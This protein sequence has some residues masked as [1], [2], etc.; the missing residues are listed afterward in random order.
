MF[1]GLSVCVRVCHMCPMCYCVRAR[2][3]LLFAQRKAASGGEVCVCVRVCSRVCVCVCVCLRVY[4][5]ASRVLLCVCARATM[6]FAQRMS[7]SGGQVC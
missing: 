3:T 5:C 6:L 7:A 2:A 4:A 1:V